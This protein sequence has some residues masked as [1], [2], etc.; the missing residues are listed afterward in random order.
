MIEIY[1]DGGCIGN[2]YENNIGGFGVVLTVN[3]K[4]VKMYKYNERNTTNNIME[5]KAVLYAIK[6]SKA[7]NTTTPKEIKIY[8]D[9]SYVVNTINK[10]MF[11]WASNNWIKKSDSKPPENINIIK[12][13]YEL[14]QY[15]RNIKIEKVKGH[16]GVE[17]N[18]MADKLATAAIKELEEAYLKHVTD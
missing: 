15:E 8:T 5:L 14:M 3:N 4:Y 1:T 17:F 11:T 7:L 2:G 13:L 9:S 18:E 10:W 6:L 16:A 12:E